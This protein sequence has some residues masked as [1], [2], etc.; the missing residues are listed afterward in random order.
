MTSVD[1][2]N[3]LPEDF[4]WGFAT[5]KLLYPQILRVA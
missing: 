5:G 2:A 3:K 1:V 4:L